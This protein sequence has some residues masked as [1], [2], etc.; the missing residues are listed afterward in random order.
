[1]S[2]QFKYILP[3]IGK[4]YFYS[5]LLFNQPNHEELKCLI[6]IVNNVKMETLDLTVSK[7]WAPNLFIFSLET[8]SI[9][10]IDFN[11][12]FFSFNTVGRDFKRCLV[13]SS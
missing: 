13:L 12:L 8:N 2:A 11:Y 3:S 6:K 7:R 1:M 4:I 10:L 9:N 5:Y